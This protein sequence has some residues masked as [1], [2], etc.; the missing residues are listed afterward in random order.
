M[1]SEHPGW[2]VSNVNAFNYARSAE[3]YHMV[4]YL[5]SAELQVAA[6]ERGVS[7]RRGYHLQPGIVTVSS[8]VNDVLIH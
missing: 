2:A 6:F 7:R 4:C 1:R 8:P 3:Q 5:C